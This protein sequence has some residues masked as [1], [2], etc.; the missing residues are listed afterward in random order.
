LLIDGEL[1]RREDNVRW[2]TCSILFPNGRRVRPL[3]LLTQKPGCV[4]SRSRSRRIGQLYDMR[5]GHRNPVGHA[6]GDG[7]CQGSVV[8]GRSTPKV[9]RHGQVTRLPTRW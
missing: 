7:G 4:A 2:Q 9:G 1:D 6:E 8:A 5:R 3:M